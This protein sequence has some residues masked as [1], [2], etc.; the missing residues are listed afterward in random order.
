MMRSVCSSFQQAVGAKES[1]RRKGFFPSSSAQSRVLGTHDSG[2]DSR[3]G[4]LLFPEQRSAVRWGQSEVNNLPLNR[5]E[6]EVG[7]GIAHQLRDEQQANQGCFQLLFILPTALA[8][9]RRGCEQTFVLALYCIGEHPER[10]VCFSDLNTLSCSKRNNQTSK[11]QKGS[12]GTGG[13]IT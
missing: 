1:H 13:K 5:G 12:E 2:H 8:G 6:E 10:L 4:L 11:L 7:G 3:S 9:S